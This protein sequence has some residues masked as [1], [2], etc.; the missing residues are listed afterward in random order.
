M[1]LLPVPEAGGSSGGLRPFLNAAA[2]DTGKLIIS[3]VLSTDRATGPFPV[4][5]LT[6]EQGSAKP[7]TGRVLRALV[8]PATAPLRALPKQHE[9]LRSLRPRIRSSRSMTAPR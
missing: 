6:G 2:D 5:G 3:W 7:T 1:L 4:L 8:G 9:A